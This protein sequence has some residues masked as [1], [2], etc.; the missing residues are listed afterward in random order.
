MKRAL[1]FVE[2]MTSDIAARSARLGSRVTLTHDVLDRGD[3]IELAP[4]GTRSANGSARLIRA[5]DGWIAVN[6]PRADDLASLPALLERDLFGDPWDALSEG[7]REMSCAVLVARAETLGLAL[8]GVGETAAPDAPSAVEIDGDATRTRLRV[9]DFSALWAGPLCGAVFA[10]L[11]ADVLKLE[12]AER[13]DPT[14]IHAPKLDQRLNGGKRKGILRLSSRDERATL[15]EEVARADVLITSARARALTG[16]GVTRAL[17]R[18]GAIWIAVT[19]HG[20][21]SARV[22]FGDDAAASGGLVCWENDAPLFVGDALA[23]PLT[24]LAAA[25]AA[26]ALLEQ[27]RGGFVDAALA[28]TAAYVA[29]LP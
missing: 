22:A 24:G 28:R 1:S 6:L 8:A 2:T 10:A 20:F 7:A 14:A 12:S 25:N 17:L 4:P 19:G 21:G 26:L 13:P 5:Q 18:E 11:G 9:V 3:S 27:G 16:M 29:A 23:D 15:L